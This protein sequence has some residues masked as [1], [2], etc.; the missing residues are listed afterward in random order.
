MNAHALQALEFERVRELLARRTSSVPGHELA[1]GAGPIPERATIEL[2]LEAVREAVELQISEPD[3]REIAFPDIRGILQRAG[4]VGA[5]LE[6]A[7]LADVGQVLE[8]AARIPRY[9]PIRGGTRRRP[10]L[11]AIADRLLVDQ[12]FPRR[13]SRSFE[14]SG[15]VRDDA[16][17]ELRK[18]R[19]ELQRVRQSA[20]TRLDGLSQQFRASGEESLVTLRGGRYV[21]S[22]AA[23]EKRQLAGIVHDRSATGKTLYVE[24]LDLVEVN[25]SLAELEADERAEIHRILRE[26]TAWVRERCEALDATLVALAE[27]DELNARGRLARDLDATRPVIDESAQSLRIVRGRHPL[28]F[29]AVGARAVPLDLTLERAA[30]GLVISGPNMGGKTVV[31][32]T[33]GLLALMA[34]SGFFVPAGE[35]TTLPWC[36]EIYVD[37]GDEQSLESDLSTYAARLRNMRAALTEASS[38]SLVLLD[39]LGAGTDPAEGAALGQALLS[40]MER[41]QA[42]CVTTTHL[43]AFKAFAA[44]HPGFENAAMEYD[45]GTLGPTYRLLTGV[46]GRSHAFELAQREGWPPAV[47]GSATDFLPAPDAR[48]DELLARIEEELRGLRADREKVQEQRQ[49]LSADRD[50]YRRLS[51]GLKER[52]AKMRIERAL[53]EDR[54]IREVR[55]LLAELRGRLAQ[56]DSGEAPLEDVAAERR[57]FHDRERAVSEIVRTRPPVPRAAPQSETQL[58]APQEIRPGRR[59]FARNLGVPVTILEGTAGSK[60][61][62]VEHRGVRVALRASDLHR[63]P[64][65]LAG[66]SGGE[67]QD[68]AAR[69]PTPAPIASAAAGLADLQ[70]Q[71]AGSVSGEIDLRGFSREECLERLELYLDR[72]VLAGYPQ[73]RIIHGKGSGILHRGVQAYLHKHRLVR[74]YR[75]GEAHE[76]GWGVTIAMLGDSDE[77]ERG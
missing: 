74:T 19:R 46:P 59:V 16:S 67:E 52:L 22:I 10:L 75:T 36:D 44:K 50:E 45:P 12:E 21:L 4:A 69:V 14:P 62:W 17:A 39:E 18:V 9:F 71:I 29:L 32:K 64:A 68:G 57:W 30:R 15:E 47:L 8:V 48:A 13:I 26:L 3:W 41:R 55:A 66:E 40:E 49:R 24:P 51:S 42:F 43:G 35:G 65:A 34:Q 70:D 25:N 72:A 76:G 31:L 54:R 20:S 23:S 56:I 7:E 11:G 28:L 53:E 27:L 33:V 6:A 2:T 77:R 61:I 37:I 73:V 60:R 63:L 38:R 1:L 5:V 58:L